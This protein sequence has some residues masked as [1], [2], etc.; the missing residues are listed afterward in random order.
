M[1]PGLGY[2]SAIIKDVENNSDW[3]N[4]TGS[5][6]NQNFGQFHFTQPLNESALRKNVVK[7]VN[8]NA[9]TSKATADQVD[10]SQWIEERNKCR[11]KHFCQWNRRMNG[12][13]SNDDDDCQEK[14]IHLIH[15]NE[16]V[17]WAQLQIQRF[18]IFEDDASKFDAI[19]KTE[20]RWLVVLRWK[21]N[22]SE[23]EV[24]FLRRM[25]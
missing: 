13:D 12:C 10:A 16:M 14:T 1:K 11:A 8:R 7:S 18:Q 23:M 5:G 9:K 25:F 22:K 21:E 24:R 19:P 4:K 6:I 17:D 20:E 2:G 15:P 3:K